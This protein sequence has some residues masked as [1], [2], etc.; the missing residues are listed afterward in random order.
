MIID[1]Q[2]MKLF[3][4]IFIFM[5]P[6]SLWNSVVF[7][8]K[9]QHKNDGLCHEHFRGVKKIRLHPLQMGK[10]SFSE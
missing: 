6:N 1:L 8:R 3:Y 7:D 10:I 4:C 9:D 5:Y 2:P